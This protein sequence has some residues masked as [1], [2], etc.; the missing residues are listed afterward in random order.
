MEDLSGQRPPQESSSI[1]AHEVGFPMV[2]GGSPGYRPHP[3]DTQE[4]KPLFAD[5]SYFLPPLHPLRRTS[6]LH[7]EARKKRCSA[8]LA[9]QPCGSSTATRV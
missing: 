1:A 6:A 3:R 5:T 9:F 8:R 2:C 7:E 4:V